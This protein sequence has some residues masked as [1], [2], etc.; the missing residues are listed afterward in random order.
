MNPKRD[1]LAVFD[2]VYGRS[3]ISMGSE[4]RGFINSRNYPN[5]MVRIAVKELVNGNANVVELELLVWSALHHSFTQVQPG[6]R[7]FFKYL[8]QKS[9]GPSGLVTFFEDRYPT[10]LANALLNVVQAL[11]SPRC[12][13]KVLSRPLVAVLVKMDPRKESIDLFFDTIRYLEN[14]NLPCPFVA[15]GGMSSHWLSGPK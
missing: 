7:H 1:G 14:A 10:R 5:P 9:E 6:C 4:S 2:S 11:V 15:Y 3:A 13:L 8:Y 12:T